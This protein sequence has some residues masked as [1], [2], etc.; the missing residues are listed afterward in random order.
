MTKVHLSPSLAHIPGANSN[1][2]QTDT[3][4]THNDVKPKHQGSNVVT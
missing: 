3:Y 1:D 4:K 2:G